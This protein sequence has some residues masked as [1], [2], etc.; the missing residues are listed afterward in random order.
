LVDPNPDR[1]PVAAAGAKHTRPGQQLD[2]EPT[3]WAPPPAVLSRDSQL[4]HPIVH[5]SLVRREQ[6]VSIEV[7]ETFTRV[8]V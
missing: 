5:S 3:G 2:V 7:V 1:F 4:E 8:L 6:V